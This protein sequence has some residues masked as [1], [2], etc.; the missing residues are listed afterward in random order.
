VSPAARA[1]RR[2][3]KALARAHALA[4]SG[5]PAQAI[6]AIEA[7]AAAGAS[8]SELLFRAG[9][10]IA[11]IARKA[12]QDAIA[13]GEDIDAQVREWLARAARL[14]NEARAAGRGDA[15]PAHRAAVVLRE[16]G[17]LEAAHA[18]AEEAFAAAPGSPE[19]AADL[20]FSY[21]CRGDTPAA[22]RIYETALRESPS[23]P[24][25]H[26]GRAYS[27]L[28]AGEYAQ[29][30][31]EYAWRLRAAPEAPARA[32][33]FPRWGG[34]PLEGRTLLV[35]S[36]QGIGDEIMFA[37]CY[38]ELLAAAAHCVIECGARLVPLL[39]RSFPQATVFA[40][41]LSQPPD[42]RALPKIDCMIEAGGIPALLRREA[43]AFPGAPYLK[44][45]AARVAQWRTRL[46]AAPGA[47]CIGIA[48]TG[49]L[50]G[51]LRALRSL[52]L[53]ALEPLLA[54]RAARF[55]ALE[56]TDRRAEIERAHARSGVRI[57]FHPGVAARID[58]LAALVAALDL[59]VCVPTAAAHL[60]GAL[61][62]PCA[63]LVSGAP[64]WRYGW[65]GSG[66]PW[67]RSVRVLRRPQG[68]APRDWVEQLVPG[69]EAAIRSGALPRD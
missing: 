9:S 44:A 3:A 41:N 54:L 47:P 10:A 33:A 1:A 68:A 11:A 65:T 39:Q 28:G 8:D 55:V 31:D 61:G 7:A 32:F 53:E 45:D 50:P 48:W 67:Y 69:L 51:T 35:K 24:E 23:D 40:R 29:G 42:W 21:Q 37:S 17:E 20:A 14:L 25:L 16:M 52:P 15:R 43:R 22:L 30:W 66:M 2:L 62:R 4:G 56:L 18:A 64:T 34:E 13:R 58:E 63:V 46:G 27:L 26:L 19:M 59:V 12:H 36:E 6:A 57:D 49:G 60:A 5:E 38:G